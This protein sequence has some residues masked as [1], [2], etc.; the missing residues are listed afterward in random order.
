M[1]QPSTKS[2]CERSLDTVS[3]KD[4]KDERGE[5]RMMG[6]ITNGK[7]KKLEE[8]A[9]GMWLWATVEVVVAGCGVC[10]RTDFAL[11][12]SSSEGLPLGA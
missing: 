5:E 7:E 8:S 10:W 4:R 1:D 2:I 3:T 9:C 11:L 6:W 12:L